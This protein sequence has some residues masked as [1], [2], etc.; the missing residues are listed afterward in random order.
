MEIDAIRASI[1]KGNFFVTDHALTEGF[2]DGIS[3]ANMLHVIQTGKI[4]ERYPGRK[5]CLI[6]GHNADAIPI[7]VVIDFSAGL[8][9]D[10][11]TTYV[12]QRDQWIKSQVRKKRK[13]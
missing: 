5:R 8:S 11:V 12:P 3:V 2:K 13:R 9:V 4:I 10:I 6:Y 1:R 7:H